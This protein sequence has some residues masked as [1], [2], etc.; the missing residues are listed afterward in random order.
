[1]EINMKIVEERREIPVWEQVDVLV[2][3]S[4]P[5]GVSA[6]VCAAREG[7]SVMLLEQTGNVGGIAT[8]GLMS[9]WTGNTEGGFYDEILERSADAGRDDA[10]MRKVI[11]PE[12]L[13]T[14]L[15]EM[16]EEAGVKLLLYTFACA[17]V[18]E[19][20]KIKG[21][22]VE[23]KTGR[24]AVLGKVVVDASGDGD[25]AARAGAPYYIGRETDGKMQPATIMF[26]VAGVDVER[27]VFP[28]GFEEHLA[29]P[30]GD[31][32]KLGEEHLPSPTGHVL[33]YRSTLPGIVTCNMTNCTDIDGTKAEDL[34]RATVVCRKQMESIVHFL[35]EYVPGFENCYLIS[36]ASLVG[37]RETRHFKG[38]AV[39]TREDILEARV[40]DDWV[41]AKAHFNFDVHNMTGN[42]LDETGVQ[43]NFQQKKGYTIP[44]GCFVPLEVDNL[45]LAGRNISGTHM[46]HSNFRV[47]PICANMGQAVGVAAAICVKE[48]TT[49]RELSVTMVQRRLIESGVKP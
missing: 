37:I 45:Y 6:A 42:G 20:N 9:H 34:T 25:I 43:K 12:R 41:V 24:G 32:Q 11:N 13:K 46:A 16:L 21:V 33:L 48:G 1:M 28:G 5:A 40:F 4:G 31:I 8:E 23:N 39:I 49:P 27:G 2:V 17:P 10:Q 36:S 7:I 35:R 29:I 22:I 3:G 15:L 19:G 26:K 44:Y 47:M 14:V 30:A 38:E 18:M